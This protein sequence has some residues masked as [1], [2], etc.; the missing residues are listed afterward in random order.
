M[1]TIELYRYNPDRIPPEELEATFVRREKVLEQIVDDLR[2]QV[3]A[4]AN[5]HFLVTGPRGVGKTNLLLMLRL[6]IQADEQLRGSYLTIKTAEEEYAIADLLDLFRRIMELAVEATGDGELKIALG[7]VTDE[8]NPEI[9]LEKAVQAVKTHS[10]KSGRKLLLLV[11]N[12]DMIIEDQFSDEAQIGRLRDILMNQS[13]L[14][15]VGAAPTFFREV[16][17]YERPLYGFFMLKELDELDF[18]GMVALLRQRADWEGNHALLDR[19]DALRPRLKALFH[20][21]GGNPRLV[22]MLYQLF[23]LTEL[24]E[25]RSSLQMLLDDM[26]PYFKHRM[27]SLAPQQRKTMDIFARLGRPATPTELASETRLQVNQMNSILKRLKDTG[28]VALAPQQRRKSTLYMVSEQLFRIWHQ[29]RYSAQGRQR[30]EFLIEFIRIWYSEAEWEKEADRLKNDFARNRSDVEK[31]A[32]TRHIEHLQYMAA[33]A[34]SREAGYEIEDETIRLCIESGECKEAESILSERMLEYEREGNK[35][36]LSRLWYLK[37]HVCHVQKDRPKEVEALSKVVTLNSDNHEAF[38]NWGNALTDWARGETG[39][40][41]AELFREA[42]E[43]Y[44]LAVA[45]KPDKHSAFYYWGIVLIEQARNE[46][47]HEQA[48]LT[49]QAI[50]KVDAAFRLAESDGNA[51]ASAFYAA[52]MVHLLLIQCN[53]SIAENNWGDAGRAFSSALDWLHKAHLEK[54]RTELVLFFQQSLRE[55]TAEQCK[56]LL[57]DLATGGFDAEAE[58]LNPFRE[59]VNY[60]TSGKNEEVLDRLNPEMRKLVEE[61]IR[62]GSPEKDDRGK[63]R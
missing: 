7:K 49:E 47:D 24:P 39:D 38:Y 40:R 21:T 53:R 56:A 28:L 45:I 61:I 62:G 19:L 17:G 6:R 44:K 36:R 37:A 52:H 51:S 32:S 46:T 2:R 57:D 14:V 10:R 23:V 48:R 30:L 43:K 35:E 59:A 3:G 4:K 29:M 22:L 50:E 1:R 41:R 58:L 63:E 16:S 18:E 13:F 27:E 31:K 11:D 60:W 42:C 33:A 8:K 15:V 25:V 26:T 55:K 54:R 20:L 5:Q 34:P 12:L 9:A